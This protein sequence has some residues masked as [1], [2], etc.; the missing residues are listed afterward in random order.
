MRGKDEDT[1]RY[2]GMPSA[3]GRRAGA[4]VGIDAEVYDFEFIDSGDFTEEFGSTYTT[5]APGSEAMEGTTHLEVI[6]N[7]PYGVNSDSEERIGTESGIESIE[8]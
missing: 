4:I 2:S 6:D 7:F 1:H 8:A 3:F 5:V